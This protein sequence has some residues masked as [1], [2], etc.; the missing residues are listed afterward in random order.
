MGQSHS[1]D[2]KAAL[3]AALG[4]VTAAA[5]TYAYMRSS[6]PSSLPTTE[7][8]RTRLAHRAAGRDDSELVVE[9]LSRNQLYFG[10]EG[11]KA[12]SEAFV[13]VVGLGGVGSHAAHMMARAGVGKLRLIDFDNLTLSSLNRHAVGT[14]DDVGRPKVEVCQRHFHDVLPTLE[15]EAINSMFTQDH[16]ES[17]LAGNPDYVIDA[18]DDINT[19][20]DLVL[21][22]VE[23]QLPIISSMGAGAKADPSRLVIGDITDPVND[24][25]AA[26]LRSFVRSRLCQ[27]GSD[28][29]SKWLSSQVLGVVLGHTNGCMHNAYSSVLGLV[30]AVTSPYSPFE[31]QKQPVF[32]HVLTAFVSATRTSHPKL[33]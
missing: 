26:K 6:Q 23:R 10:E 12:L 19:K 5:A 32:K 29:E 28:Q 27:T 14:R 22:C 2:S 30:C 11:Q 25:L 9:Q 18:I 13:V 8:L 33:N 31:P 1:S 20:A 15:I 16:A 24:P 3:A 7:P 4:A 21:A 17:L